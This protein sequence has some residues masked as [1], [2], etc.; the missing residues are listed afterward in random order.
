M[1][2]WIMGLAGSGK[3]TLAKLIIKKIK[4]YNSYD[5]DGLGI[6]MMKVDSFS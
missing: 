3:T 5:G 6:F 4:K 1:V 2:I